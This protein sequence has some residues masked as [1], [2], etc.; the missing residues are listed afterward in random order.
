MLP[1]CSSCFVHRPCSHPQRS[2]QLVRHQPNKGSSMMLPVAALRASRQCCLGTWDAL[3]SSC[4]WG[5]SSVVFFSQKLAASLA[6]KSPLPMHPFHAKN[7]TL[8]GKAKATC[9]EEQYLLV[10][11]LSRLF[12]RIPPAKE[13][14]NPDFSSEDENWGKWARY[15]TR[16]TTRSG[17]LPS[18][19]RSHCQW[20]PFLTKMGNFRCC[21]GPSLSLNLDHSQWVTSLPICPALLTCTQWKQRMLDKNL[22]LWLRRLAPGESWPLPE[23]VEPT[24]FG[25]CLFF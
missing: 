22:F 3:G 4:C 8:T 14:Q 1:Q 13:T 7:S 20:Q 10:W 17:T 21:G 15:R 24:C 16:I 12:L 19:T 6:C 9:W 2:R 25:V 18:H 11:Y 5:C 23:E